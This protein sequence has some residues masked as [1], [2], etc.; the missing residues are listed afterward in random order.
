VRSAGKWID[1]PALDR[2]VRRVAYEHGVGVDDVPD[3]VQETRIA[4]WELGLN[5]QISSALI[6]RVARNKAI[7]LLRCRLRRRA[8]ERAASLIA[9]QREED[10]EVRHLLNVRAQA[11]PAQL[12]DL[13]EL[14]YHQGLSEREVAQALGL[15]RASIRWLDRRLR[16]AIAGR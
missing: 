5:A 11:L 4:L 3:L 16:R 7:D 12:H 6:A 15:C 14:H 1:S 8:R 13:Y 9:S 10:A 2:F